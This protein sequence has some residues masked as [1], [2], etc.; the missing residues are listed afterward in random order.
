MCHLEKGYIFDP[1]TP[2]CYK[3][4]KESLSTGEARIFCAK[5]GGMLLRIN[6]DAEKN[7]IINYLSK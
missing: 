1:A 2:V 4:V 3:L 5:D 7:A 6:N